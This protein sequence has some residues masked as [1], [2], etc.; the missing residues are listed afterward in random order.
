MML[1][2]AGGKCVGCGY[3]KCIQAITFF[4]PIERL[5]PEPNP[6]NREEKVE[7]ARTK[8]P[9]CIRCQA[10][11]EAGLLFITIQDAKAK[12]PI[13]FCHTDHAD[14]VEPKKH[15]VARKDEV[16]EVEVLPPE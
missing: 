9:I 14:I 12:P 4:D 11:I 3:S 6:K 13:A 7:W 10:E 5:K 16:L 15:E 1:D 2:A 8:I